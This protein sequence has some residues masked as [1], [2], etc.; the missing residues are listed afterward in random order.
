MKNF[1]KAFF[2]FLVLAL[3]IYLLPVGCK[4]KTEETTGSLQPGFIQGK[5]TNP[6]SQ[7]LQMVIIM[8]KGSKTSYSYTDQNGSYLFSKVDQGSYTMQFSLYTYKTV[9]ENVNLNSTDT[10][11]LNVVMQP[12]Q[13]Y[14]HL[15]DS[16]FTLPYTGSN[17]SVNILSNS[18]WT[19]TNQNNWVI[20]SPASGYGNGS[21]NLVCT[22]NSSGAVRYGNIVVSD[23]QHDNIVLIRQGSQVILTGTSFTLANGITDEKDS[24]TL[25]F[26]QA[27]RPQ[28][29]S[30]AYMNCYIDMGWRYLGDSSIIRCNYDCG[31]I[32]TNPE[33]NYIVN[34]RIGNE[35]SGMATFSFYSHKI[36]LAGSVSDY[37]ITDDNST[38]W[39]AMDAPGRLVEVSMSTHQVI[40]TISLPFYPSRMCMSPWDQKLY[41]IA[42]LPNSHLYDSTL[43]VIDPVSGNTDRTIKIRRD[44]N[45]PSQNPCIFPYGMQFTSS[46]YGAVLLLSNG[47]SA[48]CWKIVDCAHN[49]SIYIHPDW[50]TVHDYHDFH[51]IYLSPDKANLLMIS[52]WNNSYLAELSGITHAFTQIHPPVASGINFIRPHW[53]TSDIWL[54]QITEQYI[55]YSN[56]S[57]SPMSHL[58]LEYSNGADFSYRSGKQRRFILPMTTN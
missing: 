23:G 28:Q 25:S 55:L 29:I 14:L 52:N 16:V 56:L 31:R 8:L 32:G 58:D 11:Q 36:F 24:V 9:I 26:N 30:S 57:M 10:V 7:P 44:S 49:D 47:S 54:G 37:Y 5:V 38:L 2:P 51:D 15:S 3:A 48:E 45:D 53:L 42:T 20:C 4:K 43:Y 27:V 50:F 46:G 13:L 6:G 22:A 1:L 18:G 33:V 39:V 21:L 34:D 40:R 41:L 17:I 12:G 19:V 35:T